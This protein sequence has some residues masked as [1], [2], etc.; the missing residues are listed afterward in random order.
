VED[1]GDDGGDN[2]MAVTSLPVMGAP[3]LEGGLF[4][5]FSF[6]LVMI[7]MIWGAALR[8][9]ARSSSNLA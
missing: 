1:R 9:A 3:A 4:T 6:I 7:S 5:D 2:V 8:E